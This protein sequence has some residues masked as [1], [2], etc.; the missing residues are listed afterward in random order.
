MI[1]QRVHVVVVAHIP[2]S[3]NCFTISL[4][5]LSS[6]SPTEKRTWRPR[7]VCTKHVNTCERPLPSYA[8]PHFIHL[9]DHLSPRLVLGVAPKLG[10]LLEPPLTVALDPDT[11][12][13]TPKL[14]MALTLMPLGKSSGPAQPP[15]C[16]A[17]ASHKGRSACYDSQ[18][19]LCL[20]L[21][22]PL[23]T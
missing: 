13:W 20:P 7:D 12:P 9:A 22:P 23:I 21:L 5:A 14:E 11:V 18:R 17:G 3:G 8:G 6:L 1:P 4:K 19:Y 16:D 10:Q 15:P 2:P